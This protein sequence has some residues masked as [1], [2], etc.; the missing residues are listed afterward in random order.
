MGAGLT[1]AQGYHFAVH[2]DTT[3]D[4][5]Q[6]VAITFD[7]NYRRLASVITGE[8]IYQLRSSLDV[9]LNV[10]ARSS[11]G[12]VDTRHINFPFVATEPEFDLPANAPAKLRGLPDSVYEA[13][14]GLQPWTG[15]NEALTG[16]NRLRN[17]EVHNDLIATS[18]TPSNFVRVDPHGG[19][20]SVVA[21]EFTVMLFPGLTGNNMPENWTV[22][23]TSLTSDLPAIIDVLNARSQMSVYLSFKDTVAFAGEPILST[24]HELAVVVEDV[25]D[26]LEGSVC[27]ARQ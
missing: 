20:E 5:P 21:G 27:P 8:I 25:I 4:G 15:G 19:W 6:I 12:L 3:P 10:L 23:V 9:A 14:R 22:D 1:M 26:L 7:T 13:V 2:P 16:L 17:E 24:L 11:V 18:W